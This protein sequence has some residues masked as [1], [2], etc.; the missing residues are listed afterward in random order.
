[1]Y[2]GEP[3]LKYVDYV[4]YGEKSK[5]MFMNGDTPP[6]NQDLL[7]LNDIERKTIII[8]EVTVDYGKRIVFVELTNVGEEDYDLAGH[9]LSVYAGDD[10]YEGVVGESASVVAG[11]PS[12]G[13]PAGAA[14]AAKAPMTAI[15]TTAVQATGTQAIVTGVSSP[16]TFA[17]SEML[18]EGEGV[19]SA[20]TAGAVVEELSAVAAVSPA[21]TAVSTVGI[22][23][24]STGVASAITAGAMAAA[25]AGQASALTASSPTLLAPGKSIVLRFSA[26]G[27]RWEA[28][29]PYYTDGEPVEED[30]IICFEGKDPETGECLGPVMASSEMISPVAGAEVAIAAEQ[31]IPGAFMQ[32]PECSVGQKPNPLTCECIPIT[33]EKKT[34]VQCKVILECSEG[35][36][37]DMYNCNCIT[38]QERQKQY[39]NWH[40]T[41]GTMI[42]GQAI[43]ETLTTEIAS[44]GTAAPQG[45]ITAKKS[46]MELAAM[47]S[48]ALL[49]KSP[50]STLTTGKREIC[51]E[52]ID[53]ETGLCNSVPI[54]E[55]TPVLDM[56]DMEDAKHV[57]HGGVTTLLEVILEKNGEQVDY[58]VRDEGK[59]PYAGIKSY[60]SRTTLAGSPVDQRPDDFV[61]GAPSLGVVEGLEA[62][63]VAKWIINPKGQTLIEFEDEY[64]EEED[65][66]ICFEG[67][68]PETG[69]CLGAV[70]PEDLDE[71]IIEEE[72]SE[73]IPK[74]GDRCQQKCEFGCTDYTCCECNPAPPPEPVE[75]TISDNT[76]AN[77]CPYGYV[78]NTCECASSPGGDDITGGAILSTLQ[79]EFAQTVAAQPHIS[80][81]VLEQPV[82]MPVTTVIE[83]SPVENAGVALDHHLL[84][85]SI[86]PGATS[87]EIQETAEELMF[88]DPC[89][90]ILRQAAE[91][92]AAAGEEGTELLSRKE[93]IDEFD[94]I[95]EINAVLDELRAS[96]L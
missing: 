30:N 27:K 17:T 52:G 46:V 10:Y 60:K 4:R 73:E 16:P 94:V 65:V 26:A 2:T 67:M 77:F 75:E 50:V 61:E 68:D 35:K 74:F 41:G 79:T 9:K 81:T 42:T 57:E 59:I 33:K 72:V 19:A 47:P 66:E 89:D 45:I 86:T 8:S 40:K 39:E 6:I 62:S 51:Y 43:T 91:R 64:P 87:E 88:E 7:P 23:T 76:C 14:L 90:T 13:M 21:Q 85:S 63:E 93:K 48:T 95:E 71:L 55:D 54:A 78:G 56:S 12:A 84:A 25:Q 83:A 96:R 32:C 28:P 70:L 44:V 3:S 31:E 29:Y 15:A 1:M 34:L 49:A 82:G 92:A 37:P 38:P 22:T 69:E 58:F 11:A 20:I 24:G 36:V 5:P 80:T 18:V 53:S